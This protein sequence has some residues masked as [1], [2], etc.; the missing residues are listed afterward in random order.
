MS[1][2]LPARA[3][4]TLPAS[5]RVAL[6]TGVLSMHGLGFAL[7][8]EMGA[9]IQG[10]TMAPTI[11]QASWIA[12]TPAE[13]PAVIAPEPAPLAAMPAPRASHMTKSKPK[14][15]LVKSPQAPEPAAEETVAAL[16]V[17]LREEA[18]AEESGESDTSAREKILVAGATGASASAT[19]SA[20]QSAPEAPLIPPSH[21]NYLSNPR[22]EYPAP[23]RA[24]GEQG[25][26][27]LYIRVSAEG[28][29]HSVALHK[30][31]GYARLDQAAMEA[32][33]RW[34]FVPARQGGRPVAG[35]VI[36]PVRFDL[37]S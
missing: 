27:Y 19:A 25:V 22:P 30:S 16:D 37:R 26:V 10:N 1:D 14:P 24:Q 13:A 23:S 15:V 7:M 33:Q 20:G 9:R 35:A 21:A 29:T 31:C 36:V 6:F 3:A 28:K 17:P 32:V 18:P 34:R 5:W 8:P 12:A 2:L 4:G 11:L